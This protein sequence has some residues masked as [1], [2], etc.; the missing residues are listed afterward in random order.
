MSYNVILEKNFHY[1]QKGS[2]NKNVLFL[3]GNACTKHAYFTIF[4]KDF[5]NASLYALDLPGFGNGQLKKSTFSFNAAIAH[6]LE[7]LEYKKIEEIIL[8][9]HSMGAFIACEF[10]SKFHEK[11]KHLVLISPAGFEAF[12][13]TEK[14][15]LLNT[16]KTFPIFSL[17][18]TIAA[19]IPVGFK[20]K[21]S[22][23]LLPFIEKLKKDFEN[24]S[25]SEYLQSCQSGVQ[26]M[27]NQPIFNKHN[28]P[29]IPTTVLFGDHDPLIPNQVFHTMPPKTF[30]L[31]ALKGISQLKL[32][33]FNDC[34]HYVQL[35]APEKTTQIINRI[36]EGAA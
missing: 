23:S 29:N 32:Y 17:D 6:I 33:L 21:T 22:P 9:G 31:K 35:E 2:G 12:S 7:F 5:S 18:Q 15:S 4:E 13:E 14:S 16:F 27:L 36:I 26:E 3:H 34:G 25:Q 30:M 20:Q 1:L 11:I 19:L 8:V 24:Y 28:F 10:A